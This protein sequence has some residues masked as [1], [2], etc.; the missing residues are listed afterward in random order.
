MPR[1]RFYWFSRAK[2]FICSTRCHNIN[3]RK[4]VVHFDN[5]IRKADAIFNLVL[6]KSQHIVLMKLFKDVISLILGKA[7]WNIPPGQADT[8]STFLIFVLVTAFKN[9]NDVVTLLPSFTYFLAD[10]FIWAALRLHMLLPLCG[11]TKST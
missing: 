2:T 5:G 4:T 8:I 11:Y 1:L 7:F 10:P 6:F 3:C 9:S